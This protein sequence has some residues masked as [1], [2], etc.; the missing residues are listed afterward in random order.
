MRPVYRWRLRLADHAHFHGVVAERVLLRVVAAG[1]V[2]DVLEVARHFAAEDP[3]VVG[4]DDG[5]RHELG[6]ELAQVVEVVL[7]RGVDEDEVEASGQQRDGPQRVRDDD[8]HLAREPGFLDVALHELRQVRIRLDAGETA[9]RR[10]RARDED[11]R[12][13]EQRADLEGARGAV[14]VEEAADEAALGAADDGDVP[15]G[16]G[17][18]HETEHP[19][20]ALRHR[21]QYSPGPREAGGDLTPG[22]RAGCGR[23]PC[24]APDSGA[25]TV[26]PSRSGRAARGRRSA[27]RAG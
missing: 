6:L 23:P 19:L 9:A 21:Q 11:R 22:R 7:F 3:G 27:A 18:I 15:E 1:G 14:A 12:V 24:R 4:D 20:R 17:T 2:A 5:A 13:A 8:L 25:W 10:Q 16:G 26:P